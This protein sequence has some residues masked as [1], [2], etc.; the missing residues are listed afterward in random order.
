MKKKSNDD[1]TIYS[2][3]YKIGKLLAEECYDG[4]KVFYA[5][6]DGVDVSYMDQ[7]DDGIL[8]K[9]INSEEV[10]KK[11]VKLPSCAEDYGTDEE[12]DNQILGFISGYSG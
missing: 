7:L 5:V 4:K 8:I 12:L 9:P 3:F 2:S 6:W 1:D 10:I 11:I